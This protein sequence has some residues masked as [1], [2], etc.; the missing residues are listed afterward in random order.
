MNFVTP[1]LYI[2]ISFGESKL[3]V[4]E[5]FILRLFIREK[6]LQLSTFRMKPIEYI[7]NGADNGFLNL[8]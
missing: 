6:Q 5:N 7:I 8:L 2:N 3:I 4:C 1:K